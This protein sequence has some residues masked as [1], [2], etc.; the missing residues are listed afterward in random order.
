MCTLSLMHFFF[1]TKSSQQV[2]NGPKLCLNLFFYSGLYSKISHIWKA[3]H[4]ILIHSFLRF[5]EQR[6]SGKVLMKFL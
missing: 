5:I 2:I 3:M 1:F 4:P 6:A